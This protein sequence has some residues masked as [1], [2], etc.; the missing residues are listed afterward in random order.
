MLREFE[1]L[2]SLRPTQLIHMSLLD[3]VVEA[4]VDL[5]GDVALDDEVDVSGVGTSTRGR[6]G[7]KLGADISWE[8]V[9]D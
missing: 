5:A 9:K 6:F 2:K 4:V 3:A 1:Y 7:T 8:E